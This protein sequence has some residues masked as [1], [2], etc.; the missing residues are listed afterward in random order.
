M[1]PV[2]TEICLMLRNMAVI[3]IFL[4]LTIS[5]IIFFRNEYEIS[6]LVSTIAVFI[7]GAIPS[8]FLKGLTRWKSFSGWRRVLLEREIKG[9]VRKYARECSRVGINRET[10]EG[11]SFQNDSYIVV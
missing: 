3:V 11:S 1:L 4:F 10:V 8:L 2:T 7:S 5:S 6:T 9:A